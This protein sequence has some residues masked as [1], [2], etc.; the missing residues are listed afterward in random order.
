MRIP[1]KAALHRVVCSVN[2]NLGDNTTFGNI[3]V[4]NPSNKYLVL[5]RLST[6]LSFSS[7]GGLST[8][9]KSNNLMIVSR[10]AYVI[11][12]TEF[13]VGFARHRDYNGY[14]P[15]HRNAGHVLRVLREVM[16][17]GN[18]V[19]SLSRLRRLTGVIRGVTLYKLNG[20]TPLPI[21][22]ALGHFHSRCRRRVYSGGYH[23]GMY[24][25]LHRF[26]VGPRF[27][28]NYNGY[29]GGYPTNT[30]SNGVGR[31]CRVSG[32]VYVGYNTYGSGYGFSTMCIRT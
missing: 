16:S 18:R 26:R 11:R 30:V 17:N 10:G 2:N 32:S 20:D 6:P 3:R 21:V 28:V 5:S 29:T 31:P 19:S 8:V 24:A 14:M 27:Y 23:T 9:V 7:I 22:D 1:V 12:I 4:N 15:Y 25:T 13:F